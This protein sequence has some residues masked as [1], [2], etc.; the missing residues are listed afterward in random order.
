MLCSS[1]NAQIPVAFSAIKPQKAPG[2]PP[3][4]RWDCAAYPYGSLAVHAASTRTMPLE[5]ASGAIKIERFNFP[6]V[7]C[8]RRIQG[9]DVTLAIELFCNK[10]IGTEKVAFKRRV[11]ESEFGVLRADYGKNADCRFKWAESGTVYDVDLDAMATFSTE[12]GTVGRIG[13]FQI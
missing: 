1:K 5:C 4:S 11:Y 3:F 9:G 7:F 6:A 13:G 10:R 12:F 2:C 8:K